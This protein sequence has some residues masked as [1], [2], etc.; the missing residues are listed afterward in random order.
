MAIPKVSHRKADNLSLGVLFI[1]FGVLSFLHSWWPGILLVIG[2]VLGVRQYLRGRYYDIFLTTLVFGGLFLVFF[3]GNAWDFIVP[4]C[5]TI[6]G[7]Y[8]IFREYLVPKDKVGED[9]IEDAG[10]EVNDTVDDEK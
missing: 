10:E 5:F 1:G 6:A 4:I 3:I 9:R 8:L 2:S 7:I